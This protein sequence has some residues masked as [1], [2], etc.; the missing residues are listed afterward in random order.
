MRNLFFLL[1][2]AVFF[3]GGEALAQLNAQEIFCQAC[4]DP[5]DHPEDWA[6]FAFNQVYGDQAWMD[7]DQADDFFLYNR[8]GDRVYVD[9][10]YIMKGFRLFGQNLPL[11]PRNKLRIEV[12]LPNGKIRAYIRSIFMHPLP[13]P[14]PD[15]DKRPG[16]NLRDTDGDQ[17]DR[18]ADDDFGDPDDYEHPDVEREGIVDIVDPDEDG[19]FPG[20]EW[21]E[22]C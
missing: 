17:N 9:V 5:Y 6:N 3:A 2:F 8:T 21:C 19:E 15:N 20:T 1:F 10:D 11:W 13:V 22:E 18:E 7:F 4:R 14:A 12:V 16:R